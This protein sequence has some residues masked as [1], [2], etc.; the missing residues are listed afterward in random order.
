[1]PVVFFVVVLSFFLSLFLSL[2]F[3]LSWFWSQTRQADW[4]E[5][6]VATKYM[7][8]KLKK[9]NEDIFMFETSLFPEDWNLST[10]DR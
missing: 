10:S 8:E 7:L 2:F 3:F 9:M 5:G 1:M 4:K 6:G